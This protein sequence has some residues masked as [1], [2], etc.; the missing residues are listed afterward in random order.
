MT[1]SEDKKFMAMAIEESGKC[2][3]CSTSYCVGAVIVTRGGE[4]FTG[5][6][7]E[8][9]P[10]NHAEEE[11]L[12]KASTAGA[13]LTGATIYSSMEPCSRRGSK[14]KSCSQLIIEYGFARV[15]Y[16]LK[17]PPCFVDCHGHQM[18]QDAGLEVVELTD[19]A[20]PVI[21]INAHI[22]KA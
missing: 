17:E 11:A 5:Y 12:I 7:H 9:G 4:L 19:S 6:T 20:P 2:V 3:P 18:L 15:V 13:D 1:E 16:A 8:S 10:A 21:E 14:P 22:I